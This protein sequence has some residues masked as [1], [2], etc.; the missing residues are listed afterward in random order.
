MGNNEIKICQGN[1]H[2]KD[3]NKTKSDEDGEGGRRMKGITNDVFEK[4]RLTFQNQKTVTFRGT[5]KVIIVT[6][7]C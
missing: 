1:N 5:S 4:S 2:Q 7:Y 3:K 6:V